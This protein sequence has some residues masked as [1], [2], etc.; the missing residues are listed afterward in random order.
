MTFNSSCLS[1]SYEE[2]HIVSISLIS[3]S[4]ATTAAGTSP[5]LVTEIIPLK[6]PKEFN[7][8]ARAF[9]FL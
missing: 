3:S 9:A 5:P 8:Q 7:R 6:G 2:M 1:P 4:L